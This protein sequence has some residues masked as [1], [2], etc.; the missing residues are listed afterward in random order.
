MQW[1]ERLLPDMHA[2]LME[3]L[4]TLNDDKNFTWYPQIFNIKP[5]GSFSHEFSSDELGREWQPSSELEPYP[6]RQFDKP[7]DVELDLQIFK[8][9]FDVSDIYVKY[10]QG[11][12]LHM[13]PKL[14]DRITD[15]ARGGKMAEAKRAGQILLDGFTGALML[16]PDGQPLFSDSHSHGSVGITYDNKLTA[17]LSAAALTQAYQL[18]SSEGLIDK[19]GNPLFVDYDTLVVGAYN[20]PLAW[21]LVSNTVKPGATNDEKNWWQGKIKNVIECPWFN[22]SIQTGAHKYWMLMDSSVH[23]LEGLILEAPNLRPATN[24]D[25]DLITIRGRS[26]F[27][28]YFRSWEGVM[29]SNGTT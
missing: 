3:N 5:T 23:T 12:Q 16:C 24:A 17:A 7:S 4:R 13:T 21:E 20:A 6:K 19:N 8:D 22:N 11:A 14:A 27:E 25:S 28:F 10:G 9:S 2:L 18:N 15:F 29:G 26:I 1:I